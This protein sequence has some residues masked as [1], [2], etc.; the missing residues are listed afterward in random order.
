MRTKLRS[1]FTLLFMSFALMLA[2]P[3][4]AFADVLNIDGD[5]LDTGNS[6]NTEFTLCPGVGGSVD[7][8]ATVNFNGSDHFKSGTTVTIT[9]SVA[10][11]A[12]GFITA[13]GGSVVTGTNADPWSKDDSVT[14]AKLPLTVDTDWAA[15][16]YEVTYTATGQ[17]AGAAAG[18]N[19][20][21]SDKSNIK[22][23]S[24]TSGCQA[25][26]KAP[27]VNVEGPVDGAEYEFGT[28]PA[29]TCSV[30]DEDAGASAPPQVDSSGLSNGLGSVTVTCSYQDSL[31]E[32]GTDSVTYTIVDTTAPV[33]D[34]HADVTAE[35]TSAD[36][37]LVSYTSPGTT[38]AVYGNGTATCLPASGSQ[39]ALGS[40]T[41]TCNA[42]DGSG[43]PAVATTFNVIVKDTTA[44]TLT[45]PSAPVVV[46]ATGP[47]GAVATYQVSAEDA[48]DPAPTTNC[49]PANGMVFGIGTTQVTCTATDGSGNTSAAQSF[50]VKVQDTTA[51][52]IDSH[53]D[54][55][56]EATGPDGA[57]VSYTSPATSDAVDGSGT[58]T[59]LPASGTKFAL[60]STKIT[61]TAKDAAGNEATTTFNVIV[62]DTTAPVIAAHA[63]VNATATGA[64]GAL[65]SYTSPGTTDAV[66][67]NG[68]ATC[69]PASGSQFAL[70]STT[71][72]CTATDGTNTSTSS[73]NVIVAYS[74]SNFLQPINVTG[75]QSVFKMGS[76]VPV[77]FQLT[78]A[79]SGIADGTF[80]LKYRYTS[81]GDGAGELESVATTTGTT[82]TMFRYDATSGQYI[83]NWSTKGFTKPGNYELLVYTDSAGTNLLGKVSIELKK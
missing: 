48:V 2:L 64:N 3:A 58:V 10:T 59:C 44:P 17:K 54:V 21:L 75:A 9:A 34:S 19:L 56:G 38:D 70:G 47:T 12:Q 50:N 16:S 8:A 29:T 6:K 35:A 49:T 53:A 27:V 73:F 46:E 13:S 20:T 43:N 39:F 82:G 55:T 77:K 26:N 42:T 23:S 65:V 37:A 5:V 60:G 67:G 57:N 4:M 68:T 66:A 79:S 61:C 41:V 32:S 69:T 7:Q 51:P 74:W 31:G 63:D 52:A 18:T 15:G 24:T 25:P 83:F 22:I 76:T 1:R 72:T 36:G 78:G 45:V 62:K 14:S 80:Y 71:V 40:T 28:V 33:I 81:P 30:D 11:A